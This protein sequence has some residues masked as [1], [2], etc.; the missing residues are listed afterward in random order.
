MLRHLVVAAAALAVLPF[1]T[2]QAAA[3]DK[4][5]TLKLAHVFPATH[6]LW[7]QGGKVFADEI[8]KRTSGKVKFEVYPAGQLGRDYLALLK[9]GLAD[10][11]IL[12]PSYAPDKLPLTSVSELPGLY[13]TS[14]EATS[15]FWKL[16]Q[17]GG[18]VHEA[19]LKGHG[20]LALFVFTLP[21]YN[22]LTT[23][24]EV[25]TLADLSGLKI[26]AGGP[27]MDKTIRALGAA[28]VRIPSPELY[29]AMTRGTVDGA[30]FPYGGLHQF[31]LEQVFRH[32]VDGVQLGSG[33]ITFSIST[34]S[35]QALPDDLRQA[36]RE[37][38]LVAQAHLCRAQEAAEVAAREKISKENGIKVVKLPAEEAAVW[39]QKVA[40]VA[41]AWAKEMDAA[42]RPG[43]AILKAYKDAR[44]D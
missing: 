38:G 37:A 13:S 36:M 40:G 29:D 12:V 24:K 27:A 3:Q 30:F 42:G 9:S 1:L 18:V 26:R 8:E 20:S 31:K 41:E 22:I 11:V 39:L 7:L 10:M 25:R 21:P 6:Y 16:A 32:A 15:R 43:S 44:P 5:I 35:W 2:P 34:K 14:C 19:E 17:E 23:S 28:P 33:T 4:Q